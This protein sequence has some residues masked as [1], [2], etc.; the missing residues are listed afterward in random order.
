ML[1]HENQTQTLIKA[2]P[3][4]HPNHY[5]WVKKDHTTSHNH[6]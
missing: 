4:T 2:H 6:D 5:N 1:N 3:N